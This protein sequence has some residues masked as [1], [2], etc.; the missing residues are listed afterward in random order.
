MDILIP[1]ELA[2]PALDTLKAKYSV[3][4]EGGLWRHPDKLMLAVR[5]ARALLVR[6]QT[7]VTSELLAAARNLAGVGRLG[8]GLDNIDLEAASKSGVVVIAPLEA[9]ATSVAELAMG[10]ILALAR[11]I[12]AADRSTKNGGWDRKGCMGIE[13]AGKTLALCGFGRIGKLVASRARAFGMRL[14]VFDPFLTRDSAVLQGTDAE[15][16]ST[17]EE[18]L[19]DADFVSVHAPLTSETKRLF[20][21]S[22]FAAMKRGSFFINTSR[23]GLVDESALLAALRNGHLAGAAL[24]VRE[25]EPPETR[26]GFEDLDCV[27]LTPH[28][29]AATAEAQTRTFETVAADIDR[30]LRGEAAV[31]YVNFSKPKP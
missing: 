13:V 20:N 3:V 9:N 12:P 25:I 2:T 26:L 15:L 21:A 1:E 16:C 31:N 30:L 22:R 27:I 6:N 29:G 28:V 11:K 8:V 24:D 14:L 10:L 17:L 7:Q 19:R 23:G 5:D 18:A 4:Y